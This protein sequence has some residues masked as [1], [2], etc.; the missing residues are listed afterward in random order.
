[1]HYFVRMHNFCRV[2]KVNETIGVTELYPFI[3]QVI[4]MSVQFL[5]LFPNNFK[6]IVKCHSADIL[7]SRLHKPEA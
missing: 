6:S 1:M 3:I 7:K 5:S 2:A 4:E